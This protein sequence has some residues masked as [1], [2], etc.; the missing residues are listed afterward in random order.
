MIST[1][2][3]AR[4][5]KISNLLTDVEIPRS[6][7]AAWIPSEGS[8]QLRRALTETERSALIARRD[9]LAP[10]VLGFADFER[11]KVALALADMF[12]SFPSMRQSGSEVMARLDAAQRVLEPYPLW[13]IRRAC[14]SIQSN[15][16][17]RE[18]KFDRQWPPSDAEIVASVRAEMRL[19]VNQYHS[20]V[21]L[22]AATVEEQR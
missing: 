3:P 10:A 5:P 17:W 22:L 12:G 9:E 14:L 6:A 21:A 2:S 1:G 15:G 20:A 8:R 7:W 4:L 16:V 19:F 18:E 11:N 13:A